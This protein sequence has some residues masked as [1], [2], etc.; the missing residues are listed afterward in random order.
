M[1]GAPSLSEITPCSGQIRSRTGIVRREDSPEIGTNKGKIPLNIPQILGTFSPFPLLSRANEI[2]EDLVQSGKKPFCQLTL[3]VCSSLIAITYL[4]IWRHKTSTLGRSHSSHCKAIFCNF[5][6]FK[7]L[8][9][10]FPFWL[11]PRLSACSA[12]LPLHL[13]LTGM[14]DSDPKE[15]KTTFKIL[16]QKRHIPWNEKW[17]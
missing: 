4:V 3:Q 17:H 5:A 1:R 6:R 7:S 15:E 13:C 8:E 11:C 2:S 14:A 16:L 10:K 9:Q 12:A